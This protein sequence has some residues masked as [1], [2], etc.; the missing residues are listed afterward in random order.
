MSESKINGIV[1][2]LICNIDKKFYIGSTTVGID[3][4]FKYHRNDST[5]PRKNNVKLYK[6]MNETGRNNWQIR[7]LKQL[8]DTTKSEL[9]KLEYEIID[10][11]RLDN[12]K[13]LRLLNTKYKMHTKT[14][15]Q[16]LYL[17]EYGQQKINCDKCG[18]QST[19]AHIKEHKKSQYCQNFQAPQ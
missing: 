17:K 7:E 1:Y 13:K 3:Q 9:E 6:H 15:A 2:A 18:K 10:H 11:C 16:K 12:E 4:R 14:D 5:K 19:K 8:L